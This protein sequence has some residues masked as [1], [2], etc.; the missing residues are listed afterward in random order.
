MNVIIT[1]LTTSCLHGSIPDMIEHPERYSDV[2]LMIVAEPAVENP[3]PERAS[4]LLG[5]PEAN[6]DQEAG[7]SEPHDQ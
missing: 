1:L 3:Q 7:V 2:S 4:I 6:Q 5:M